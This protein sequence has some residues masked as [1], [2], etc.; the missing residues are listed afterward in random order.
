MIKTLK[1]YQRPRSEKL[2]FVTTGISIERRHKA[3]VEEKRLNLSA[4][5]RDVLDSLM[6]ETDV[7]KGT[8]V[9]E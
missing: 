9:K 7:I 5:V 6:L 3:F 4:L 1:D 8:P 2:D